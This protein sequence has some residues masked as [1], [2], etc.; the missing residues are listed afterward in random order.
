LD[1]TGSDFFRIVIQT[2]LNRMW[3]LFWIRWYF[4]SKPIQVQGSNPDPYICYALSLPTELN[5][6]DPFTFFKTYIEFDMFA[7]SELVNIYHLFLR[8]IYYL[9]K[10][11]PEMNSRT[12]SYLNKFSSTWNTQIIREMYYNLFGSL[13]SD[14][15]MKLLERFHLHK[16]YYQNYWKDD[17]IC[18]F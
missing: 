5:S 7:W 14:D 18:P 8:D 9:E 16:T 1:Q 6:H 17:I 10:Y 13:D 15:Y 12:F 4:P 11:S 2:K 3:F